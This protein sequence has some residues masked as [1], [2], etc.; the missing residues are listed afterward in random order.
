MRIPARL[1]RTL[2][3]AALVAVSLPLV[4]PAFAD[5]E[6]PPVIESAEDIVRAARNSLYAS[7]AFMKGRLRPEGISFSKIPFQVAVADRE[8]TFSFYQDDKTKNGINQIISLSLKD[9]RY[10][11]SETIT[12]QEKTALPLERY[13]QKIRGT[14]VT[15][16]D[17]AMRFLYW[18]DPVR[19]PDEQVGGLVGNVD[20]WVVDA[21]NPIESGP[22]RKVRVWVDKASGATLR[23]EGYDAKGRLK[24]RFE[25][26]GVQRDGDGGWVP[27]TVR[28][29]SFDPETGKNTSD[30]VMEF[31]KPK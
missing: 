31:D 22:Y 21:E 1:S 28:V 19:Q 30:T 27:E 6:P 10:E 8:I 15:Y 11:M 7:E 14:D 20:T 3:F 17:I 2:A 16:E 4:G 26:K 24:K 23:I 18:P 5:D 25:V 12:G 13:G 9:N 29:E